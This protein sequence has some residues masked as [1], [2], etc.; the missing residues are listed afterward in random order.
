MPVDPIASMVEL[1]HRVEWNYKAQFIHEE[2]E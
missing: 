1:G 2:L